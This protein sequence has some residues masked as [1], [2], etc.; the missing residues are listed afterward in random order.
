MKYFISIISMCVLAQS[1][2]VIETEMPIVMMY[3]ID[4]V[5]SYE[6]N[7]GYSD[8]VFDTSLNTFL[9][10]DQV[11]FAP[12]VN[13]TTDD[14]ICDEHG[15]CKYTMA[16]YASSDFGFVDFR[17]KYFFTQFKDDTPQLSITWMY[18]NSFD[19][20]LGTMPCNDVNYKYSMAIDKCMF[21]E[22]MYTHRFFD[23]FKFVINAYCNYD[24]TS[25]NTSVHIDLVADTCVNGTFSNVCN[26]WNTSN[27]TL[28]SI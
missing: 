8:I 5:N 14:P 1:A 11:A 16:T 24:V 21:S 17:I 9:P 22:K 10:G 25:A 13:A 12:R 6:S 4:Q 2:P 23:V 7:C 20:L 3:G 27:M 19:F 26:T 28:V 18:N 15:V